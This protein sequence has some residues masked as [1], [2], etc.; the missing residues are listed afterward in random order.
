MSDKSAKGENSR[1]SD[2]LS[3]D[4]VKIAP[5]VGW[6]DALLLPGAIDWVFTL[7]ASGREAG[8]ASRQ[9]GVASGNT[10][11][12]N[13]TSVTAN[14]RTAVSNMCALA[15]DVFPNKTED[16]TE[17]TRRAHFGK[18]ASSLSNALTPARQVVANACA[19]VGDAEETMAGTACISQIRPTVCPCKTDTFF[20]YPKTAR[21]Q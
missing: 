7:Y 19:G 3:C 12:K 10:R 5:G 17:Q 13:I 11:I 18:C 20:I 9:S 4:A 16:P 8:A 1:A 2:G 15:G 21:G 14:A 6:R